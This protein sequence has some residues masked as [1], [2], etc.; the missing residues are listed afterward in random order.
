MKTREEIEQAA[1][2]FRID[3]ISLRA[4]GD[5]HCETMMIDFAVQQVNEALGK[6]EKLHAEKLR[7]LSVRDIVEALKIK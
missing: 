6:L 1:R 3:R 4:G 2:A 7:F 5:L